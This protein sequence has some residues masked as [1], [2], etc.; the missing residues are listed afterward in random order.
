VP[1]VFRPQDH[2]P[3]KCEPP[4]GYVDDKHGDF[5]TEPW[6]L[7]REEAARPG[8]VWQCPECGAMW[9]V[10]RVE[11]IGQRWHLESPKERRQRER[12]TRKGRP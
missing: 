6:D 12:A 5:Y 9:A 8:T 10:C 7:A 4:Y 2:P 3:H 11:W 1:I